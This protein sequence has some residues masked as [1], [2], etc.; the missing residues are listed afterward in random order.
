[1]SI[2]KAGQEDLKYFLEHGMC[3]KELE[4]S[5]GFKGYLASEKEFIKEYSRFLVL[6]YSNGIYRFYVAE[7][8]EAGVVGTC[9]SAVEPTE[10]FYRYDLI[11]RILFIWVEPEYRESGVAKSMVEAAEEDLVA[12]GIRVIYATINQWNSTPQFKLLHHGYTYQFVQLFR[13]L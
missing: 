6:A 9:I 11:G 8:D 4:E 13:E 12:D 5:F 3:L 2:R 10:T 1:M 7:E